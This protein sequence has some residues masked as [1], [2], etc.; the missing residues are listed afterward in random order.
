MLKTFGFL[1]GR[2]IP[3]PMVHKTVNYIFNRFI[4]PLFTPFYEAERRPHKIDPL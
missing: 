1:L 3:P 2:R 4:D